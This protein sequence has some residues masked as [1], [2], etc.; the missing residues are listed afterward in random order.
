MV[1]DAGYLQGRPDEALTQRLYAYCGNNPLKYVDPAGHVALPVAGLVGG[2][3][4]GGAISLWDAYQ[5]SDDFWSWKTVDDVVYDA[6]T[7][8]VGRRE[9]ND[10]GRSD[11]KV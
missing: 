3:I 6:L 7:G 1:L 2:G 9:A 4:V 10:E 11:C 8:A 5:N